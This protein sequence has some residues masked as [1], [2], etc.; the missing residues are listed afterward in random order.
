M[1]LTDLM[2][3]YTEGTL[4]NEVKATI[5]YTYEAPAVPEPSAFALLGIGGVALVGYGWRRKRRR[6]A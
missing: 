2:D 6:A 4:T 5:T 1:G 3:L